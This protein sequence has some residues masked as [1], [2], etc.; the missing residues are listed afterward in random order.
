MSIQKTESI[1]IRF[2]DLQS[3]VWFPL[4][5]EDETMFSAWH[6]E[7]FLAPLPVKIFK[8]LNGRESNNLSKFYKMERF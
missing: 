1:V 4:G 7:I 3:S 8:T 5:S 6:L 2:I